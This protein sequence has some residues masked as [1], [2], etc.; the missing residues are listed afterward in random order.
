MCGC[1]REQTVTDNSLAQGIQFKFKN[2]SHIFL[3]NDMH[4][5]QSA[6]H[7]KNKKENVIFFN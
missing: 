2:E 3:T 7:N 4:C 1:N 5:R 6:V